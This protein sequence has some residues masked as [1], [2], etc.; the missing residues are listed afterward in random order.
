MSDRSSAAG[1]AKTATPTSARHPTA[2]TLLDAAEQILI[3]EGLTELSTRRIVDVAD[4]THGSIRYHFGSLEGLIVAVVDR[5]TDSITSRQAA[6]YASDVP[7]RQKWAQ[8]MAWFEADLAAGYPKLLA[9]LSAAAWNIPA[10][11]PGC[12]RGIEMW[13]GVLEDAVRSAATEYGLDV[14]DP[15]IVGVANT[16]RTSQ[17]GMLTDRLAGSDRGHAEILAVADA[18]L[19]LLEQRGRAT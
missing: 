2:T 10:C 16:I 13:A 14:A 9:E 6:M 18:L 3:E 8:A 1:H 7:F 11:R 12:I 17:F 19:T 4:Q 5:M 15:L